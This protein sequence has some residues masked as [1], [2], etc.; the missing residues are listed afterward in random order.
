M[1]LLHKHVLLLF[2]R[3]EISL[4]YL[5]ILVQV[6]F[7]L[8]QAFG[9]LLRKA[10]PQTIKRLL[11]CLFGAAYLIRKNLK[12]LTLHSRCFVYL[13]NSPLNE[14]HCSKNLILDLRKCSFDCLCFMIFV[15]AVDHALRTYTFA[16]AREAEVQDL[17]VRVLTA[18][19]DVSLAGWI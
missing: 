2:E 5:R 3:L 14:V 16:H 19:Y 9:L 12:L 11:Y 17:I 7:T 8:E 6:V 4:K 10:F 15:R 18:V 1:H 13:L